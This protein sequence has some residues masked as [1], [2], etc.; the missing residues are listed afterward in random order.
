MLFMVNIRSK[1]ATLARMTPAELNAHTDRAQR[2]VFLTGAG[3]SA[4]SGLPTYTDADGTR[5]SATFDRDAPEYQKIHAELTEQI[6][7]AQPNPALARGPVRRGALRVPSDRQTPT[8][9]CT[10]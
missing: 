1:P 9:S 3:V 2:I 7:N 5:S 6:S 8:P 4:P 10:S